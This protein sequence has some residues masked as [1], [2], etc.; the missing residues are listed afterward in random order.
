[1]S[2]IEVK[3]GDWI[4]RGL[5]LYKANWLPLILA[6]VVLLACVG[7]PLA[8]LF[9]PLVF[10]P[11]LSA[12]LTVV[13]TATVAGPLAVGLASVVLRLLNTPAVKLEP[14]TAIG[15]MF[16][17]YQQ[18]KDASLL[19]LVVGGLPALVRIMLGFILPQFLVAVLGFVV[20]MAVGAAFMFSVWLLAERNCDFVTALKESWA[21]VKTN[22]GSFLGFYVV[23]GV[24]AAV[25]LVAC[26]VGIVATMPLY[27]CLLVVAYRGV[28]TLAKATPTMPPAL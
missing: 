3:F 8:V 6:V 16:Q 26:F 21:V 12:L 2:A 13:I 9:N 15:A 20:S 25:G 7:V 18:F 1:M 14:G 19:F 10:H 27:F 4:N 28:F 11:V 5:A 22:F 17:G 24:L 23:A